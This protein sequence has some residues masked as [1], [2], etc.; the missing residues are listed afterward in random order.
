MYDI[1]LARYIGVPVW[2]LERVPT[3]YL[4]QYRV[5][6]DAEAKVAAE[7]GQG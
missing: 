2:E 1:Q 7:K 3:W 5:I 4:D 6:R